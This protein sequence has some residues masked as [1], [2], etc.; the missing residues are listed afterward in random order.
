M[1]SRSR[2][3]LVLL[4]TLG[5][6]SSAVAWQSSASKPEPATEVLQLLKHAGPRYWKGNLHTHSLWSDGDDFPEMIADWY[7]RH[8]YHF[9]TLSDH[10]V[11]SEGERWIDVTT[12]RCGARRRNTATASATAGS[13][14][15]RKKDEGTQ[16]RL[17]PLAE[18]RSVLEE[19]GPV[20]ADSRRGDHAQVRQV[21]GPHERASTCATCIVAD[22]RR[23]R[24]RDDR[25]Q[26]AR[27]RGA[28]QEDGLARC[29]RSSIIRTSA[30]ASGPR[31]CSHRGAALLRDLQ[32]P[33]RRQ[34]TTATRRT[35]APNACGTSCSRCG[36]ASIKLPIVYGLATDDAHGYHTY[37]VGKVNPGRGWIMVKA[38]YL[39]AEAIVRAIE[40]GDFYASSGVAR[41]RSARRASSSPWRSTARKA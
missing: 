2:A 34:A 14:R 16:V 37:G 6:L 10:N 13:K 36:S 28:A 40:A 41:R 32:R 23:Q 1:S 9:L 4:L 19:A 39:T 38:P 29:W 25:R 11:L 3:L 18:F 30:G 8:G 27:G 15:R 21:P 12:E 17:K 7:K 5:V 20:S 22:R 24:R 26:P 33:S 31:T 35:P